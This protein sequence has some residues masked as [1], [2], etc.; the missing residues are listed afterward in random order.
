MY[1]VIEVIKGLLPKQAAVLACKVKPPE[2]EYFTKCKMRFRRAASRSSVIKKC[3]I[4]FFKC[5][6]YP[7][8][9]K[10]L[11]TVVTRNREV[12]AYGEYPLTFNK[13]FFSR[14]TTL[15]TKLNGKI[16]VLE[17][18]PRKIDYDEEILLWFRIRETKPKDPSTR[19]PNRSPQ[20]A[21]ETPA[22]TAVETKADPIAESD[23][24]NRNESNDAVRS[25]D[26]INK[27]P[28]LNLNLIDQSPKITPAEPNLNRAHD[29]QYMDNR[30][31]KSPLIKEELLT[32]SVNSLKSPLTP[33]DQYFASLLHLQSTSVDHSPLQ[34]V[35]LDQYLKSPLLSTTLTPIDQY[36][37]SPFQSVDFDQLL[38]SQLQSPVHA[39]D[40]DFKSSLQDETHDGDQV[41]KSQFQQ[42]TLS[43]M[44]TPS[45]LYITSQLQQSKLTPGDQHLHSQL[46]ELT[47]A[48]HKSPLQELTPLKELTLDKQHLKID[49]TY[50]H[51][52]PVAPWFNHGGLTPG[53]HHSPQFDYNNLTPGDQQML[54][55][56]FTP[57]DQHLKSGQLP[58][59][60][61]TPG[62]QHLKSGQPPHGDFTP[63]DQHL[64]SGQPPH[65]DFTP[66]DQHLKSGQPPRGVFTPGD[67]HLKS[68]QPPRGVFI[69]GDQHLKSGQLPHGGHIPGNHLKSVSAGQPPQFAHDNLTPGDDHYLSAGQF[70]H[71]GT[72]PGDQHLKSVPAAHDNL[73]QGDQSDDRVFKS[74]Q[75]AQFI[76]DNLTQGDQYT[77]NDQLFNSVPAGQPAQF[78]HDNLTQ[79]DQY[80]SSD[81][82]FKS[83]LAGQPAQFTHSNLTQGDQYIPS[84]RLFK[85]V[86]AGQ[87]A[88]FIHDNLTQDNQYTPGDQHF[89]SVP[90]GQPTHDNLT[91]GDQYTPSDQL[92]KSVPAGQFILAPGDRYVPAQFT[93]DGV[94]NQHLKLV[95]AQFTHDNHTFGDQSVPQ[96]SPHGDINPSDHH[97][98]SF[99][100]AQ[101][102]PHGD[103]S[104]SDHHLK[105]FPAG[106]LP[107]LTFTPGDKTTSPHETSRVKQIPKSPVKYKSKSRN[108][109]RVSS[110]SQSKRLISQSRPY[111]DAKSRNQYLKPIRANNRSSKLAHGPG[112][113]GVK[114]NNSPQTARGSRTPSNQRFKTNNSPQSPRGNLGPSDRRFKSS[115]S[116]QR[117][118]GSRTPSNQ[119]F[120]T[121]KS[122]LPPR[123]PSNWH[124]PR[125]SLTPSNQRFKTNKSPLPP[126]RSLITGDRHFKS[127]L[128]NKQLKTNGSI[129]ADG[130]TGGFP[131]AGFTLTSDNQ[132]LQ[133]DKSSWFTPSI[134]IPDTSLQFINGDFTRGN[135]YFKFASAGQSS[136]AT[137]SAVTPDAEYFKLNFVPVDQPP[138]VTRGD[139]TPGEQYLVPAG[140]G[141]FT[142]SD[143][144]LVPA[145]HLDVLTDGDQYLP[146]DQ[147]TL[148]A[149]AIF[150]SPDYISMKKGSAHADGQF[151]YPP[152]QAND[153]QSS[154]PTNVVE[155]Q[156]SIK[157]SDQHL[158]S[159]L[160]S[161]NQQL[162]SSDQQ[163]KSSSSPTTTVHEFANDQQLTSTSQSSEF[164]IPDN[165]QKVTSS[166]HSL[167]GDQHLKTSSDQHLDFTG[168]Q[169]PGD[170]QL[171]S[172]FLI[173]ADQ[174]QISTADQTPANQTPADRTPIPPADQT[175]PDQTPPD[176]TPP[177]DQTSHIPADQTSPGDRT[178]AE[179]TPPADQISHIPA[180]QTSP[181]EQTPPDQT[182]PADQTSPAAAEQTPLA[183][184]DQ[185]P[186][187]PA[188]QTSSAD[189]TPAE[190]TPPDQ[191]PP[192]DQISSPDQIPADWT[193]A[194]QTPPADQT[195]HIPADQT[196]ADQ[197][198]ADQ[199][200]QADHTQT[201]QSPADQITPAD[202][203][204]A[205]D[206]TLAD[207]ASPGDQTSPGDHTPADQSPADQIPTDQ[208]PAHQTPADQTPADQTP[209]DQTPADQTPA[210]QTPTDQTP[211][212]TPADQT[213][214]QTPA[215]QTPADQTPADQTPADQ[216]PADQTPADQ[217]PADQ[218]PADQTPADQIPADHD[219][220]LIKST[221][222][223]Q[224]SK[225]GTHRHLV[226]SQVS[227]TAD[228]PEPDQCPATSSDV[229]KLS[230]SRSKHRKKKSV[231]RSP[232]NPSPKLS[233]YDSVNQM[234]IAT[235]SSIHIPG[236]RSP[237]ESNEQRQSSSAFFP[238]IQ[239]IAHHS[240]SAS[241]VSSANRS[242]LNKKSIRNLIE[243]EQTE[244][245]AQIISQSIQKTTR[246]SKFKWLEL[247]RNIFGQKTHQQPVKPATD[248]VV[249]S[250]S[251]LTM[252]TVTTKSKFSIQALRNIFSRKAQSKQ[253]VTTQSEQ[254]ASAN[255][256]K[257]ETIDHVDGSASGITVFKT[258]TKS[259]FNFQTLRNR[260]IQRFQR[261]KIAIAQIDERANTLRSKVVNL[262]EPTESR[263]SAATVSTTTTRSR[264]SF[265]AL[266][267]NFSQKIH[268]GGSRLAD[269]LPDQSSEPELGFHLTKSFHSTHSETLLKETSP[270]SVKITA[271]SHDDV[272]LDID[273]LE[274]FSTPS[275]LIDRFRELMIIMG[276]EIVNIH[277]D[278]SYSRNKNIKKQFC[279]QIGVQEAAL[280]DPEGLVLTKYNRKMILCLLDV[281]TFA[282]AIGIHPPH[283]VHVFDK[284]QKRETKSHE[285]EKALLNKN[286]CAARW[287]LCSFTI[288][289][290]QVLK[291]WWDCKCQTNPLKITSRGSKTLIISG[292]RVKGERMVRIQ[293][294]WIN[295]YFI[296]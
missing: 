238:A 122:P 207:Q 139:R 110:Q 190:Q 168:D 90:A 16:Q 34:S 188:D 57:G 293:V 131:V 126:R 194:E 111:S 191:T 27:L 201:D 203:T 83:V 277:E 29:K 118:R 295:H 94:Q 292:G 273:T 23:S 143:R 232:S 51:H 104:P 183:P 73:T 256:V 235:I 1:L 97:F 24:E 281:A 172:T 219:Q 284:S 237:T 25:T 240:V 146:G 166:D 163:L 130:S 287:S 155:P 5:E 67:Q 259:R 87:P 229:D 211:D 253:L 226:T 148:L 123:G 252:S 137:F 43:P 270:E 13:A 274:T 267:R 33:S 4:Y 258:V 213:P 206:Q 280:F 59:G 179:Q 154:G 215:D 212:Q 233:K 193:P 189:R 46:K 102:L 22:L 88:Q 42:S 17:L 6:K 31:L 200:P 251:A 98:K 66:G 279:R 241:T 91:Q 195:S 93:R 156:E 180:D 160:I 70:T 290:M 254:S 78:T 150:E 20:T 76:H 173:P 162:T 105:S 100:A 276:L 218:T 65:G 185:T 107:W 41:L 136:Q 152:H 159:P 138:Q 196:L 197:T 224:S 296:S 210:D 285:P 79:G 271:S 208:T 249:G 69:P 245:H 53:Y 184:A 289:I 275:N 129:L 121:N 32:P 247:L 127:K 145:G 202:Q 68:G 171:E 21:Y 2:S 216:T 262:L 44:L 214:D 165:F 109:G 132:Y 222:V 223:G 291:K 37:K 192:A 158:E 38:K 283:W 161:D 77:P 124:P 103:T 278:S 286:V 225:F 56:I 26:T 55:G 257:S 47:P 204:P 58:H 74:G 85:S 61:F 175:S 71:G 39:A 48:D 178:P 157:S 187:I 142:P 177:A 248:E 227:L 198:L 8:Q 242:P 243:Q 92:F 231:I 228:Q 84:D 80:T 60:D 147:P 18:T 116:P 261:K 265:Q 63:G 7:E 230:N 114:S 269:S 169:T 268:S 64:K 82:L 50:D 221:L 141:N 113:Q 108:S 28:K 115:N 264:L 54:H 250:T 89:K 11:F 182:P 14:I 125:R 134:P 96:P 294:C 282:E 140:H 99:L 133:T 176:Q 9:L 220:H 10:F 101:P 234:P 236:N 272:T 52:L 288:N 149:S 199:T 36:L 255:V 75:P 120:K 186:H 217:T 205:V 72:T 263:L 49:P 144:Y 174:A 246:V 260:W 209:T 181:A 266:R 12:I 3:P 164:P 117:A 81:R 86:L 151:I 167:T 119:R 30:F 45:N 15:P 170:Q 244:D 239:N 112:N 35:D 62:D 40:Q 19:N 95:P 135:Q 128:T 153:N 106:R